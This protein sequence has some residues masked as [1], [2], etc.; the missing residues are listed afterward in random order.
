MFFVKNNGKRLMQVKLES[1]KSS[2]LFFSMK[3]HG[4]TY[5]PMTEEL[6]FF[7]KQHRAKKTFSITLSFAHKEIATTVFNKFQKSSKE[8]LFFGT[9]Y[10][11]ERPKLFWISEYL[12]IIRLE[13][14]VRTFCLG[15]L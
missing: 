9:S 11:E 15:K 6:L 4:K 7:S 14:I 8:N 2:Q 5:P 3:H 1:Q 10:H 13:L 12:S